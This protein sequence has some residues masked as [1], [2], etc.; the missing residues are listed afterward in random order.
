MQARRVRNPVKPSDP[1]KQLLREVNQIADHDRKL[2]DDLRAGLR[3]SP[4]DVPHPKAIAPEPLLERRANL[5][6]RAERA[7]RALGDDP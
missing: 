6:Q 3:S 2:A 5:R 1:I 7:L 4:Q